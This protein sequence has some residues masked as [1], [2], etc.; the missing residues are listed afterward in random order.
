VAQ[1][2]GKGAFMNKRQRKKNR[3]GEYRE[4]GYGLKFKLIGVSET[5]SMAWWDTFIARVERL[6]L[7][8]G[9]PVGPDGTDDAI[10]CGMRR[11]MIFRY[12]DPEA[13]AKG[14]AAAVFHGRGARRGPQPRTV[15][16]EKM[17]ELRALLASLP[18]VCDV[19]VSPPFDLWHGSA[20]QEGPWQP[21][22]SA[23]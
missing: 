18:N 14:Y 8:F 2:V 16:P 15:T 9:G 5:Q 7:G 23:S 4:L 1:E 20:A 22:A 11:T 6:S 21:G 17:Q 3:L 12:T 13:S 19:A 10:I